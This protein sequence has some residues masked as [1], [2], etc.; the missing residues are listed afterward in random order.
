MGVVSALNSKSS[1]STRVM[2]VLR[3]I[4]YWSM[5]G[6]F[7]I[8]GFYIP[9]ESNR[10]ADSISRGQFQKLKNLVPKEDAFPIPIPSEFWR[11]LISSL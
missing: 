10:I 7:Q 4:V 5:V 9:T 1:K 3:Y 8:K 2:N 6:N 11:L